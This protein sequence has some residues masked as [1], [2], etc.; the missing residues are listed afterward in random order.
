MITVNGT[1]EREIEE[2][3]VPYTNNKTNLI[4]TIGIIKD[5]QKQIYRK[6]KHNELE[7]TNIEDGI[8]EIGSI[9]KV[10]TSSLLAKAIDE[11]RVC[12]D[13]SIVQYVPSLSQ[14]KHLNENPVTLRHL[15]THTSGL[16]SLPLGFT[17]KVLF[18]KKVRNN[19]YVYFSNQ[20]MFNFLMKYKF[21]LERRNFNY[22]NLGVGLLGHILSNVYEEDYETVIQNEICRPMNLTNTAIRL[23]TNQKKQLIPGFDHKNR[24]VDNWDFN[25][26]EGAGALRSTI[27]D[28]L[29]FLAI[30]MD[31][32]EQLN[33]DLSQTHKVHY[34]EPK[35]I[36]VGMNWII[37]KG[38]NVIWHNGGTGGYSSF[39]GFHKEKNLGIVA[40]SN[41]APSFSKKATLDQIGFQLLKQL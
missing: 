11:K 28:Q 21:H 35:G 36:S 40:L 8:Y 39:M 6:G 24:A 33:W 17:L 23:S 19:P 10:Y 37:D 34:D 14:N 38:K 13:D 16:P 2:I 12:L 32:T 9:T 4:L 26:L 27:T 3:I 22:S 25:A 1:V 31:D 41:Y 20:D 30:Q 29:A 5:G 15:T 7:E 18:S